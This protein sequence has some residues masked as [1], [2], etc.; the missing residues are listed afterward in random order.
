MIFPNVIRK[1]MFKTTVLYCGNGKP[2]LLNKKS[3]KRKEFKEFIQIRAFRVGSFRNTN[4][5]EH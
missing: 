1:Y 4:S 2:S 5:A 3:Q